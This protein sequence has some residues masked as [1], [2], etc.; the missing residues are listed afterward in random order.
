M[1][2]T[3]RL[4][5]LA[6][7]ALFSAGSAL[8]T[9]YYIDPNSGSNANDGLA[10]TTGGGHGPLQTLQKI[11]D[12]GQTP[13]A[14]PGDTIY[15]CGGVYRPPSDNYNP[16]GNNGS[17][18]TIS[19]S[20]TAGNPI[21]IKPYLSGTP[22]IKGSERVT[23]WVALSATDLETQG[24]SHARACAIGANKV[25]MK[26]HWRCDGSNNLDVFS[27]WD[28]RFSNPQQIF[29][30]SSETA[31]SP[32]DYA[33]RR[34]NAK[35]TPNSRG[36]LDSNLSIPC[37]FDIV[38]AGTL[39]DMQPGTFYYKEDLA[40][41]TSQI[42]VWLKDDANPGAGGTVV[43]A[44]TSPSVLVQATSSDGKYLVFED[45]VIKHSNSASLNTWFPAIYV[46]ANSTFR[47]CKL[48]WFD[49]YGISLRD[50]SLLEDCSVENCGRSGLNAG[51][52]VVV[53][54]CYFYRNFNTIRG[55]FVPGDNSADAPSLDDSN[56]PDWNSFTG[57]GS[58]AI[59]CIGT[60]GI[61]ILIE[62]CTF[63]KNKG[64]VWFDECSDGQPW[65]TPQLPPLVVRNNYFEDGLAFAVHVEASSNALITGN[66]FRH[67]KASSNVY[68]VNASN[69]RVSHNLF[70]DAYAGASGQNCVIEM[71][72][73]PRTDKQDLVGN[74]IVDNVFYDNK[75]YWVLFAHRNGFG[76]GAG[77]NS[78]VR[79]NVIDRNVY[80]V[81][82]GNKWGLRFLY[83]G[84]VFFPNQSTGTDL[85]SYHFQTFAQWAQPIDPTIPTHLDP[86]PAEGTEVDSDY[87]HGGSG[88][89]L[90]SAVMEPGIEGF[91]TMDDFLAAFPTSANRPGIDFGTLQSFLY[92]KTLAIP[93]AVA[94]SLTTLQSGLTTANSTIT[95]LQSS[96]TTAGGNISSI[97]SWQAEPTLSAGKNFVA[98]TSLGDVTSTTDPLRGGFAYMA[99]PTIGRNWLLTG[100][101]FTATGTP[102]V[103]ADFAF[104]VGAAA[105]A[106]PTIP[107][108][109]HDS[110]NNRT[111]IGHNAASQPT[112]TATLNVEG[113]TSIQGRLT[114]PGRAATFARANHTMILSC[115]TTDGTQT[116]AT[117]DGGTPDGA[118]NRYFIPLDTSVVVT[119][120]VIAIQ[121]NGDTKGMVRTCSAKNIGGTT[122]MVGGLGSV[123]TQQETAS[124]SWAL[125]FSTDSSTVLKVL[126]SGQAS[127]NIHWVV[128]L[129]ITEVHK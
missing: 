59:K 110:V 70:T 16:S 62:G 27:N 30:S 52:R 17:V 58:G 91:G 121:D 67:C 38:G 37:N 107:R 129:D 49:L 33:L 60:P 116:E 109:Y 5:A 57:E 127:K 74:S 93:F 103:P 95:T 105:N 43:E 24:F 101:V 42:F 55:V 31:E 56:N 82:S 65:G 84:G 12:V 94:G 126:V 11:L 64:G 28:S 22:V 128:K 53:R 76:G 98:G 111:T 123:T 68:L 13:H 50:D 83:D 124:S 15:L 8:A 78:A 20:G 87:L 48:A 7:A 23:G 117:T 18:A 79:D 45:L 72:C 86:R 114:I 89:D 106:D 113:N 3:I 36:R 34:V 100:D 9:D 1:K 112:G 32:T 4:C 97:Q 92:T 108:I 99:G 88:Y 25:Y 61:S 47:R 80:Y 120:S 19:V 41:D 71:V 63:S 125:A 85:G 2:N 10:P 104:V 69:T 26:D 102:G 21:T 90:N 118:E 75:T 29:V 81:K 96:L 39:D 119:A 66:V 51:Q 122:S 46:G 73:L 6:F 44:S 115:S 54:N 14:A 40:T 77:P 35:D